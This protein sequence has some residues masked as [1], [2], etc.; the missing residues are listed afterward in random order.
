MRPK[1]KQ[2]VGS[3]DSL[4]DTMTNVVGILVI[5]LAVT[6]L[7]VGDAV[8]RIRGA[9]LEVSAEEFEKL[10]LRASELN[11]MIDDEAE[12]SVEAGQQREVD[13]ASLSTVSNLIAEMKVALAKLAEI[14]VEADETRKLIERRE[15]KV[16]ALEQE[17][18]DVEEQL[19]KLQ[20]QLEKTPKPEA[21]TAKIVR[22][23][24]PREVP[25]NW[26]QVLFVCRNGRIMQ[27]DL[28]DLL[29]RAH[30]AIARTYRGKPLPKIT[31]GEKGNAREGI[32]LNCKALGEIFENDDVGD[33]DFR[34]LIEVRDQVPYLLYEVRE[35]GGESA[36][37]VLELRSRYQQQIRRMLR[38]QYVRFLVWPDSFD[39]YL[40]ARDITEE[41]GIAAG[42][43]LRHQDSEYR[44][45]LIDK[46]GTQ[47]F[48]EDYKPKPKPPEPKTPPRPPMPDPALEGR[49][50][51][52]K[53]IV[54]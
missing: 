37:E 47:V 36:E 26:E 50:V 7:G 29:K 48:C 27:L 13:A 6:Q 12:V 40:A 44:R 30:K 52:P 32:A 34:V 54:D 23:P 5:L 8:K 15:E 2:S 38:N 41:R 39:V 20:E 21:P 17:T 28:E 10:K 49:K 16:A 51:P 24:N 14:Q 31:L 45:P 22:L 42:W 11:D 9:M 35:D 25:R 1:R 46:R 53:D 4:L 3:L 18:A 33:A 19:A 43:E